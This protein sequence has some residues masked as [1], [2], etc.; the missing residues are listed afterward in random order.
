M[1]KILAQITLISCTL[2]NGVVFADTLEQA[3]LL[4]NQKEYQQAYDLFLELSDQG[5]ANS[6]FWLG[7]TQYKMGQRFEAGDTMLQAAN[8]GDPWAM[9]VLGG[10]VL[11]LSPP[12]EYM[13]WA[14][15]DAWQDK[16]IK[17]WELQSK[18]GNGKATYARDLSKR[19]WWEYIPFY[20]RKLYQQQA[21]TGVAQGGYR[22]FNY[23]LY[24]ESTEK[25]LRH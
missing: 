17:I 6:T 12:C 16:A 10:G 14:C 21:E 11:Y 4:F 9:G 19:D 2:L 22:Y 3:K 24:W 20:S 7:V 15:D 18:Q 23:S 5:D 8:M 25:K 13:G 1:K